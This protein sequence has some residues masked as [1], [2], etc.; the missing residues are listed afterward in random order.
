MVSPLENVCEIITHMRMVFYTWWCWHI[1][2]GEVV[3]VEVDQL[4][5]ETEA[6]GAS[7]G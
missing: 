7:L 5:K 6:N 1:Y 3:R 2:K 4:S